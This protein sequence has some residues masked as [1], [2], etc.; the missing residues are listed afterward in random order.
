MVYFTDLRVRI[1]RRSDKQTKEP[2]RNYHVNSDIF[3]MAFSREG[4]RLSLAT[5]DAQVIILDLRV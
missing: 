3:D 4:N 5:M 1:I 2:T